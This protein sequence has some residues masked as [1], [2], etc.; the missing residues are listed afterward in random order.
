MKFGRKL[1]LA[2]RRFEHLLLTLL[3]ELADENAYHRHLA[4]EGRMHS[5]AEWR[6]FCEHRLRAKYARAKCC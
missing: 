5:A 6:H 2:C 3:G 1:L 4:A